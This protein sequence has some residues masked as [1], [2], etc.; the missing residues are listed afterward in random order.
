MVYLKK[1]NIKGQDYYY[2]FHTVR[3]E[4]KFLKRSRYLGK[5]VPKNIE[6]IKEKFLDEINNPK[7]KS[8]NE[9]LIES[10]T[11][12]ERKV[13]PRL[14][15]EN[16]LHNLTKKLNIKD[17]EA[18]RA[19]SWLE[20][21]DLVK[22]DKEEK[23]LINL[24]KNGELYL[25]EGFPE[26]Q[27][28][29]LL[30]N[31]LNN[32]KEKLSQ[33]EVNISIGKLKRLNAINFSKNITITD[34]GKTLL[35][36]ESKEILF[37]KKLPLNLNNLNNEDNK[38]YEELK[39]RKNII[40]LDNK[41]II[42]FKLTSLGKEIITHKL[43]TN[44]IESLDKEMLMKKSWK[45]KT[46]RRFNIKGEVPRIYPGRMHFVN[47][48][49]KYIR[50]IW[51]D[52][53]FKEMNGDMLQTSFWNFDALYT[54]QDHPAREMQDTFFIKDPEHGKLPNIHEK[55]KIAHEKGVSGSKGY[56]YSWSKEEA[57]RN[58][59]RTHNTVL[60][61]RTI[62]SLKLKDL[63]LKFFSVGKV[64]RN[65]TM[66]WSH[67]FE[68]HQTEGIVV[69]ENV[70]FKHLLGYLKQFF[71]KMGFEKV[72]FRPSFFS[73]TEPSVE[74]V[75][76]HPVKK[77]WIELGGAGVFRPEV[78][79]PLLGKAVPVLAWGLGLE[80]ILV[81]YYEIKDLRE[82]YSNDIKK[83]REIKLFLK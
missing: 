68:F 27:F 9:K 33:D 35:K 41:K 11:P 26:I 39:S 49:I 69:D 40:K 81:D 56:N 44:L 16:N 43:K 30:P 57:S 24:D 71:N 21:K 7:D 65:E 52:L 53:G 31:T 45:G 38:I 17:V 51:L 4:S 6:E 80:R 78:V 46:F 3:K 28:L 67:L 48:A 73:F 15:E 36:E 50:R 60:S 55:V 2:L 13:F 76:Y 61:A 82:I 79:Q 12:L 1:V 19:L 62:A 83:L 18:L 25:K 66:D 37:L 59:L 20:D 14:K 34:K 5:Q 77:I 29:K 74:V 47:E 10:L 32:I 64:F 22:I 58:V 23:E 63:P 75:V 70:D 72:R 8:E 42:T 54:A